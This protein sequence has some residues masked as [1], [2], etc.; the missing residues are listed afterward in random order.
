MRAWG[1]FSKEAGTQN[2]T[3]TGYLG[4]SKAFLK[5]YAWLYTTGEPLSVAE[6]DGWFV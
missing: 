2:H 6:N 3:N 1:S 5:A 4:L